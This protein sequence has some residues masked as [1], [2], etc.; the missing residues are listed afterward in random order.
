M[1]E[2]VRQTLMRAPVER[3]WQA[4]TDHREFGAW[5]GV[6]LEAPF[7]VG[8]AAQGH[9]TIAGYEHLLWQATVVAIEPPH[10]FAFTWHPYA[11][12][13]DLDYSA[14]TPTLVEY[15]LAPEGDGTRLTV[16]ESGFDRIPAHRR[17]EAMRMNEGGWAIQSENIR[18]YV[19]AG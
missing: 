7:A 4:L 16:R 17:D 14:E 6:A 19:D 5:F 12:D 10:R 8:E 15:L 13:P 1:S 18:R 3:V 9:M 11:V 2:I